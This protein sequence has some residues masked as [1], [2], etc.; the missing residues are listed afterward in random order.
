M[1]AKLRT[2]ITY[3]NIAMTIALVFAMSGGAYAASK[4]LITSTKQISPKVLKQLK[5]ANGNNGATGATGPAGPAGPT[6]PQGPQGAKGENGAAGSN[7]AP[8][9]GVTTAALKEGDK[10]CA[11]GGTELKSASGTTFACNG[12]P[13]AT[14]PKGVSEKGAWGVSDYHLAKPAVAVL[15]PITFPTPLAKSLDEEHVHFIGTEAGF[16]EAHEAAAIKNGECSGNFEKP[17]ARTGNLCVFLSF[18]LNESPAAFQLSNP[19]TTNPGASSTGT[20]L[21]E[22]S[23]NREEEAVYYGDWVVTG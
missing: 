17:G 2:R 4:V 1:L 16:K 22:V 19:E 14:L 18:N 21:V 9:T 7:G 23:Q 3:T 5:G 15:V 6:G 8:G 11:A 13:S 10:N 12:V 20:I